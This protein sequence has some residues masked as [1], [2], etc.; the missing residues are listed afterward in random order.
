MARRTPPTIGGVDAR[1]IVARA[2]GTPM[3][4]DDEP[5]TADEIEPTPDTVVVVE[6][7]PA[8]APAPDPLRPGPLVIPLDQFALAAMALSNQRLIEGF[9]ATASPIG[10]DAVRLSRMRN[11]A[12]EHL[13]LRLPDHIEVTLEKTE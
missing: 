10:Q 4:D 12:Y 2:L 7:Q 5:E 11:G 6:P 3:P 9:T 1:E 13:T 8:T